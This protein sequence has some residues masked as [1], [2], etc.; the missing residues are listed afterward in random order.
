MKVIGECIRCGEV[1]FEGDKRCPECGSPIGIIDGDISVDNEV[2]DVIE[3]DEIY[4]DYEEVWDTGLGDVVEGS[5]DDDSGSQGFHES[6]GD[7]V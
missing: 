3:I 5:K 6:Y 7:W 2:I 1:L 4:E